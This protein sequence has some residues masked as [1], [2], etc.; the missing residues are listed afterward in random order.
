MRAGGCYGIEGD[1]RAPARGWE[2]WARSSEVNLSQVAQAALA[3]LIDEIFALEKAGTSELWAKHGLAL[4]HH[5]SL[6][7]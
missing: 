7:I 1:S 4:G 3:L 2:G 5:Y 6:A